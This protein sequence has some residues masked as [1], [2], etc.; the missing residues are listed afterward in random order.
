[1]HLKPRVKNHTARIALA[2]ALL[3]TLGIPRAFA[4]DPD[5][6]LRVDDAFK[7]SA[8][9]AGPDAIRITWTV[10]EGYFLYKHRFNF[11]TSTP[12]V[13]LG[14]ADIPPG[15]PKVDEFFGDV[16]TY[17]QAV[18]VT[19]PVKSVA[20]A[21][22]DE[23]EII[24]GSQGCADVGVCYPPHKQ[25]VS[26]A[27]PVAMSEPA[28][29]AEPGL[30]SR[31]GSSLRNKFGGGTQ[32]EFLPVE[33]A[34]VLSADAVDPYT[35]VLRWDI[36]DGYYLYREK[37][38]FALKSGDGVTL[39]P[40]QSPAGEFKEDESFGRM[41]VYHNR[42]EIR[43]PMQRANT[44]AQE[45]IL[46]ARYQ[47]CAEAGFC[48][49][50]T[51][52]DV[53][54]RL[55]MASTPPTSQPPT[56]APGDYVSEQDRYAATL[57]GGAS[58]GTLAAFFGLGLLLAFTPC[59]FPMVPILS[60]IIVGQGA[61]LSTRKAF[62]LSLIYVLP[63]A[64]TYTIA[65]VIAGMTGQNLQALFQE[66]WLVA[67]FAAI[68]VALAMSMF[69]FYNLQLPAA[70]QSKL[71]EIS[72]KQQGGTYI[73]VAIMGLLSALIVGPCVAA[74]LAGALIY[75][76]QSGDAVFGGMALFALSLG[77]GTPLLLIGT[78][79]GKLLPRVGGWMNTVKAV[80]GVMLLGLAIW[81]LERILPASITLLLWGVLA[82]VSGVYLGA[83]RRLDVDATGWRQ[84][85]QGMGVVSLLYGVLLIVGA[86]GG[87]KDAL[88]P[89]RGVF[90]SVGPTG[91]SATH[92]LEFRKV[93]GWSGVKA[94]LAAAAAQNQSVM[95]DFYADWCVSCKE[96]EKYTFSDASVQAALGDAILLQ[97][98]VTLN[99]DDDQALLKQFGIFGPPAILF[100]DGQGAERKEY[101]VVGFMKPEQF[102]QVI[103]GALHPSVA[104]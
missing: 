30:F 51:K 26:V 100:F 29:S 20:G 96:M 78:S 98:D 44:A 32:G 2:L 99:D 49:P 16:E 94:E 84:F 33:R 104:L 85:W 101:R 54:L 50:P 70:L 9:A 91:V 12:N 48:Y 6:L 22:P 76:S 57:A 38:G 86:S 73:G 69:G 65:G 23:V 102:K 66:P 8:E 61:G 62:T 80:F 89:L 63:M 37:F 74:P 25:T 90:A 40:H 5:E 64:L 93:K 53:P 1:M 11:S 35:A 18:S 14:T 24:A 82:I 55:A 75:I 15:K 17:R 13:E 3:G 28:P 19:V 72:N 7:I 45:I 41:E 42:V 36:A 87:G 97:A 4:V 47:G 10:A 46:E 71:S 79:A 103:D 81:M 58:F 52:T 88:Q 34:F 27:L 77:M 43:L 56:E 60:S 59:I 83:L 92:E 31:L 68:F 67:S 21:L 39:L 95:L